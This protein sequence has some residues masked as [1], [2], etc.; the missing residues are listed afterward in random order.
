MANY[1]CYVCKQDLTCFD[2]MKS[3]Q[4]VCNNRRSFMTY[5]QFRIAHHDRMRANQPRGKILKRSE[6]KRAMRDRRYAGVVQVPLLLC[7]I[8]YSN[9]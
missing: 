6:S 2:E 4:S 5:K 3:H 7:G 8:G 9:F 1:Q